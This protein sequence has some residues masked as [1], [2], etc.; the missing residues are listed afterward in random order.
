MISNIVKTCRDFCGLKT[1]PLS[2]ASKVYFILQYFPKSERKNNL[3]D[4]KINAQRLGWNLSDN[5]VKQ[6]SVL[7]E[8]LDL[9]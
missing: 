4:A 9:V 5:D 6:G 7:L 3:D 8:K 2:Y 1:A